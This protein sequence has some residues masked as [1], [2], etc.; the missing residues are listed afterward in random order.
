ME[1]GRQHA[2]PGDLLTSTPDDIHSVVN[3]TAAIALSLNLYELSFPHTDARR[4]DPIART[5]APLISGYARVNPV[6]RRP[7]AP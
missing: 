3:D 4:F 7:T 2:G 1:T 6:A 5:E